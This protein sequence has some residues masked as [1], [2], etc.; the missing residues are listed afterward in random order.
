MMENQNECTPEQFIATVRTDCLRQAE[1][2]EKKLRDVVE[3]LQN[4][5]HLGALGACAG[6]GEDIV[7]LNVFLIRIA[8]LTGMRT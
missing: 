7:C 8:R 2:A 4:E 3:C 5:N 1:N 6:L